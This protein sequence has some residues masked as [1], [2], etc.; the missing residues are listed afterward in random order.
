MI[1][2]SDATD[3]WFI[4]K[5]FKVTIWILQRSK[6]KV[7]CR[8][9]SELDKSIDA[10]TQS[11]VVGYERNSLQPGISKQKPQNQQQPH[12]VTRKSYAQQHPVIFVQHNAVYSWEEGCNC[13]AQLSASKTTSRKS[14]YF[15]RQFH[16]KITARLLC[17]TVRYTLLILLQ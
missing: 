10:V 12:Y 13:S 7:V 2:G 15:I 11:A 3:W 17:L 9:A 8:K 16:E 4:F 6:I 14:Q 1:T 5:R